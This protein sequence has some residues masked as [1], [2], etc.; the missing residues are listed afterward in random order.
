MGKGITGGY[1]PLAATV[2]SDEIVAAFDGE[3]A[4]FRTFFHGHSYSGNQLGCAA[5]RA[6][7]RLL[8]TVHTMEHIRGRA[9][10]L[11]RLAQRFWEHPSVGDVRC[12][13]MICAIELVEDFATR[14]RFP[15]ERRV[16]FRVSEAARAHGLI[17][18]CIGDVL[19]LMPPYCVTDAQ[20]AQAV[21]G[22]WSGLLDVLPA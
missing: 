18:R 7:L 13:G 6:S 12:E 11:E 5:A 2:A 1:L 21:E 14:R 20:I 15:M 4:E 3:Y 10:V 17:T 22:L 9:M 16:G 19:V 8:E